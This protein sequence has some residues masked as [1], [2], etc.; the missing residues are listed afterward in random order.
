VAAQ[1]TEP[2]LRVT[3]T[4]ATGAVIVGAR[5]T[6]RQAG[7]P[8]RQTKTGEMFSSAL[9][10]QAH[11]YR[12]EIFVQGYNVLNRVNLT[13]F[14]GVLTSPFFGTAT[15]SMPPR[16]LEVGTRLDF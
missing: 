12:M 7:R 4:D 11:R 10:R 15:A 9:G 13:G 6:V 1:A 8:E 2:S 16:R 5:V 14:R 3:V